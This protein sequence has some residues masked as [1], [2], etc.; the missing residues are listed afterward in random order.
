MIIPSCQASQH[1]S[2]RAPSLN[3]MLPPRRPHSLSNAAGI[4]RRSASWTFG[5]LSGLAMLRRALSKVTKGFVRRLVWAGSDWFTGMSTLV[6]VGSISVSTTTRWRVACK[7]LASSQLLLQRKTGGRSCSER[8]GQFHKFLFRPFPICCSARAMGTA[9]AH[10]L[11]NP[12]QSSRSA[13][14]CTS[15]R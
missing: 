11:T 4:D 1:H 14:L 3:K 2:W 13:F 12:L 10:S 15:H 6:G 8:P 9:L 5:V 7:W